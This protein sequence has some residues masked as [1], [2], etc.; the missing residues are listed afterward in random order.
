MKI[1][2]VS[3]LVFKLVN[4]DTTPDISIVIINLRRVKLVLYLLLNF[5]ERLSNQ[6]RNISPQNKDTGVAS[7]RKDYLIQSV[8]K[9]FETKK[10]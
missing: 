4:G 3:K 7:V 6:I 1:S 2:E 9:N 5:S 8:L 10:L